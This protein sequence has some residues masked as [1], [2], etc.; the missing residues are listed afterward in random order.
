MIAPISW[1]PAAV[2]MAFRRPRMS[3]HLLGTDITPTG[4]THA[5]KGTSQCAK[6][7]KQGVQCNYCAYSQHCQSPSSLLENTTRYVP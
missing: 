7:A 6:H 2:K 5:A 3:C 4:A 1:K